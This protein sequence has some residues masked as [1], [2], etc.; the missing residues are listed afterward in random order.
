MFAKHSHALMLA[1]VILCSALLT[2]F[3]S[4]IGQAVMEEPEDGAE[5][6]PGDEV[7]IKGKIEGVTDGQVDIEVESNASGEKLHE[8]NGVELVV[9]GADGLFEYKFTLPEDGYYNEVDPI[10]TAESFAVSVIFEGEDVGGAFFDVLLESELFLDFSLD[11]DTYSRGEDVTITGSVE[12]SDNGDEVVIDVSDPDGEKIV[13]AVPVTITDEEF[14]HTFTI[15]DDA[16]IDEEEGYTVDVTYDDTLSE[17]RNFS[18]EGDGNGN[19]EGNTSDQTLVRTDREEYDPGDEVKLTG[20]VAGANDGEFVEITVLGP[21]D[22]VLQYVNKKNAAVSAG[23]FTYTFALDSEAES[24]TYEATIKFEQERK[25][26]TFRV[27]GA[28]APVPTTE[29]PTL[30][31]P[32]KLGKI[33]V[34]A[35]GER[36]E[37]GDQVQITGTVDG[38]DDDD[39]AEITVFGPD[40]EPIDDVDERRRMIVD[41]RYSSSFNLDR[42]SDLGMY[43]VLVKALGDEEDTIFIVEGEG[44]S[45]DDPFRVETDDEVYS[46]GDSV[47]VSGK[48]EGVDDGT[49]L[50]ITVY[51]PNGEVLSDVDEKKDSITDE[52]FTFSFDLDLDSPSGRYK[53]FVDADGDTEDTVFTVGGEGSGP[54]TGVSVKINDESLAIGDLAIVTITVQGAEEGDTVEYT[55]FG[56]DNNEVDLDSLSLSGEG[57]VNSTENRHVFSFSLTDELSGGYAILADFNGELASTFFDFEGEGG[58]GADAGSFVET[59]KLNYDPG[60]TVQIS[61]TIDG[62]TDSTVNVI[63]DDP[64]EGPALLDEEVTITDE[65]FSTEFTLADDATGLFV[66]H[67]RALHDADTFGTFFAVVDDANPTTLNVEDSYD[68]G[69][70][71]TIAGTSEG[72]E[73]GGFADI[74]VL[75]KDENF[76]DG[77]VIEMTGETFE[78]SFTI[79]SEAS[80]RAY[81]LVL[82]PACCTEDSAIRVFE[83]ANEGTGGGPSLLPSLET[84]KKNYEAGDDVAIS[85]TFPGV[86]DDEAKISVL[87]PQGTP[88]SG[89]HEEPAPVTSGDFSFDFTLAEDP[90]DGLYRVKA[91]APNG[92]EVY[93]FFGIGQDQNIGGGGAGGFTVATENTLYNLG[94]EVII[95]G[96]VDGEDGQRVRLEIKSPDDGEPADGSSKKSVNQEIEGGEYSYTLSISERDD[97]GVYFIEATLG[98]DEIFTYFDVEEKSFDIEIETDEMEYEVGDIVEIT[99]K[100][101]GAEDGDKVEITATTPNGETVDEV[102]EVQDK[103]VDE[104]FEFQFRLDEGGDVGV[105]SILVNFEDDES[106]EYGYF[107]VLGER[108]A[109][110]VGVVTDKNSYA[111]GDV[112]LIGG[113]ASIAEDGQDIDLSVY[114]PFDDPIP[115]AFH[116]KLDVTEQ[117]FSFQFQLPTYAQQGVYEVHAIFFDHTDFTKFQ[118][119]DVN[120]LRIG[121]LVQ[122]PNDK[123]F[124]DGVAVDF[125]TNSELSSIRID[126]EKKSVTMMLEGDESTEGFV[127]IGIG[128][129]LQGEYT[130]LVDGA[131]TDNFTIQ[132]DAKSEDAVIEISYPHS[133]HEVVIVGTQVVPEFPVVALVPLAALLAIIVV[134]TRTNLRS[135]IV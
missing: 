87:D 80:G 71:V 110:L 95:T 133:S 39:E 104:E 130:V 28:T 18:V 9:D 49:D 21:D 116:E 62:V 20:S 131:E 111:P 3:Q 126:E 132:G 27:A 128:K 59:D 47:E 102:D 51:D 91:E 122:S 33:R 81:V 8:K 127:R 38:A 114:D 88:V 35:D 73:E 29:G 103:V 115:V 7:T 79:D 1:F 34:E 44:G 65:S 85:G 43:R 46:P 118:V 86:A 6:E 112:V 77:D 69:E 16:P 121:S 100:V 90:E 113:I 84:D 32:L 117:Q 105:Y 135:R 92:D 94:N 125:Q 74:S 11:K 13:N 31:L 17:T 76:I 96:T 25:S 99:G 119:I 66:Y 26:I 23:N 53:V 68:A 15:P 124:F 107:D 19:V 57:E 63:V 97:E 64:E 93:T 56:P 109:E 75:D 58:G 24:G 106:I 55:I 83:I 82:A 60:D 134:L 50:L 123:L 36:Y 108:N 120:D 14:T 2:G 30:Q 41:E 40:N 42:E 67:V 101:T 4:A 37:Q 129:I 52:E 61:G 22:K 10:Y 48:V 98:G 12:G 89:A 72:A 70:Q 78:F 45:T 54:Q 5:F